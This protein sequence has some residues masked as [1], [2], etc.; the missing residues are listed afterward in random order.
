M[1]TTRKHK[2]NKMSRKYKNK[3]QYGCS[4]RN[5]HRHLAQKGG[6]SFLK[7]FSNVKLPPVP[8]ALIGPD[9]SPTNTGSNHYALN[10]YDN[11]V[12]RNSIQERSQINL[13]VNPWGKMWGGKRRKGGKGR[14]GLIGRN[15]IK[16]MKQKGGAWIDKM[17]PSDLLNVG[18]Y[19][20]SNAGNIYN[21]YYGYNQTISPLPW[22]QPNLL[23]PYIAPL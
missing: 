20:S 8:P 3:I 16:S 22:N 10:K 23:K 5:K 15:R 13:S 4:K 12:D 1:A 19:A 6:S 9:W 7:E 18:R 11:Q 17:M 21:G 14:K 2:R